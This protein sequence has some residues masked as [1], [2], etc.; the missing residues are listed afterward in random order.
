MFVRSGKVT[1]GLLTA[2]L[3][4]TGLGSGELRAEVGVD[5]A[6]IVA[7]GRT[8]LEDAVRD[9]PRTRVRS[10]RIVR[11]VMT[12]QNARWGMIPAGKS[13]VAL[14][15]EINTPNGF[16]AMSGWGKV[17]IVVEGRSFDPVTEERSDGLA[18]DAVCK[19]GR[20]TPPM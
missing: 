14:C 12:P 19:G 10:F 7:K 11:S 20:Q 6:Q 2:T 5:R 16:G 18:Y 17:A 8:L 9:F 3:I 13:V 4:A 15:G 1:V